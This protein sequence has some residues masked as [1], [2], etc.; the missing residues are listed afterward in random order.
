M[1]GSAGAAQYRQWSARIKCFTDL[2]PT[3]QNPDPG[4]EPG[5]LFGLS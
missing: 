4:N 1:A 5:F 2:H 3:P